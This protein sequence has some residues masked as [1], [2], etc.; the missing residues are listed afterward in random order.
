MSAIVIDAAIAAAEKL[1]PIIIAN[2]EPELAAVLKNLPAGMVS[3]SPASPAV[4]VEAAVAHNLVEAVPLGNQEVYEKLKKQ[5]GQ[6]IAVYMTDKP[7][8]DLQSEITWADIMARAED[9]WTRGGIVVSEIPFT[10]RW[11]M[12]YSGIEMYRAGLGT[13]ALAVEK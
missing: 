10:T 7:G 3:T 4:T 6:A 11:Q 1:A 5:I 12:L 13:R 8:A 2:L 9:G